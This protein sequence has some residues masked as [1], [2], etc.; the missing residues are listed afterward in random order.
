MRLPKEL[1]LVP[2]VFLL[3]A[4]ASTF[5]NLQ[6]V[7][8]GMTPGEVEAI[9]GKNYVARTVKKEGSAYTLYRY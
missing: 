5:K 3:V 8:R 9:M 6:R 4:C 2:V 7:E 1:I